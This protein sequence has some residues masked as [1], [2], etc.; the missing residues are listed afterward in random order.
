M[1]ITFQTTLRMGHPL[2]ANKSVEKNVEKDP[3]IVTVTNN[4]AE[5]SKLTRK[6]F[7]DDQPTDEPTT[8]RL[9]T[10]SLIIG[11]FLMVLGLTCFTGSSYLESVFVHLVQSHTALS[12]G[13]EYLS[14][15][16]PTILTK[17]RP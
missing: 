14:S 6:A 1:F 11:I 16:L 7:D 2:K 15:W 12:A 8:S 10:M 13:G 9:H 17:L 4:N 3:L 5:H